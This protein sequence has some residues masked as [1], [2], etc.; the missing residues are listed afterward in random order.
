MSA[1]NM[2]ELFANCRRW[3]WER[4]PSL[5]VH[6][7]YKGITLRTGAFLDCILNF[8]L[9]LEYASQLDLC[10]KFDDLKKVFTKSQA[11]NLL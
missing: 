4:R 3:P 11:I 2:K 5:Y 1:W 9:D 10:G 8:D 6:H 7:R